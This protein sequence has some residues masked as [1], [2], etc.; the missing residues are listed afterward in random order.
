MNMKTAH[1][2]TKRP[3]DCLYKQLITIKRLTATL[4]NNAAVLTG[5]SGKYVKNVRINFIKTTQNE[6]DMNHFLLHK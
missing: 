6:E 5:H 2:P 1:K 3:L 4:Y